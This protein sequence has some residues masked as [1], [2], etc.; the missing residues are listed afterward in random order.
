MQSRNDIAL[1]Q[2]AANRDWIAQV[3]KSIGSGGKFAIGA[4]AVIC[5]SIAASNVSDGAALFTTTASCIAIPTIFYLPV[6]FYRDLC[7]ADTRKKAMELLERAYQDWQDPSSDPAPYLPD[8]VEGSTPPVT[9]PIS[10]EPTVEATP[11]VEDLAPNSISEEFN[12]ESAK[13]KLIRQSDQLR[14]ELEV[15]HQNG[16]Q[17]NFNKTRYQLAKLLHKEEL[18]E[19][20]IF[21]CRSILESR[22]QTLSIRIKAGRLL[23][24]IYSQEGHKGLARELRSLVKE[25]EHQKGVQ[26]RRKTE[27]QGRVREELCEAERRRRL[28]E[29]GRRTETEEERAKNDL[30]EAEHENRLRELQEMMTQTEDKIFSPQSV[31][32]KPRSPNESPELVPL[33]FSEEEDSFYY[34]VG[35]GAEDD[36]FIDQ[37]SS[38]LVSQYKEAERALASGDY[39][40]TIKN[41]TEIIHYKDVT[42][43]LYDRDY[44]LAESMLILALMKSG[45]IEEARPYLYH[46]S[47]KVNNGPSRFLS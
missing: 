2:Q 23:A 19:E 40:S 4:A 29:E 44:Q 46:L 3:W 12:P 15:Y 1:Q 6:R 27:I 5:F 21:H 45:R 39:N 13:A 28:Q 8:L 30:L 17:K 26:E 34:A 11:P 24:Q 32:E 14:A 9:P 20:A 25:A 33:P 10:T 42:G 7:G 31:E 35:Y 22:G 41:C 38:R 43:A 18:N 37:L 47:P 36:E 16:D